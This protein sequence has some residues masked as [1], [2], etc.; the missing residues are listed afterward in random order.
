MEEL[1]PTNFNYILPP[2]DDDEEELSPKSNKKD[3]PQSKEPK[4]AEKTTDQK[5]TVE[6]EP[7]LDKLDASEKKIIAE[8]YIDGRR[9]DLQEG[10]NDNETTTDPVTQAADAAS[11]ELLNQIDNQ[12]AAGAE[13]TPESLDEA[14]DAAAE[15]LGLGDIEDEGSVPEDTDGDASED[16]DNPSG[17]A[18]TP[19]VPPFTPPGNQPLPPQGPRPPQGPN[20]PPPIGPN[21]PPVPP[22]G[23]IPP[24][25]GGFGPAPNMNINLPPIR[26][27]GMP[28]IPRMPEHSRHNRAGD[29]LLGGI[30]GYLIGRRRGRI[31]TERKLAPI[32]AK[33][34]EQVTDLQT[35]IAE[36]EAKI[37]KMA[38]QQV[39][40]EQPQS[41]GRAMA[42]PEQVATKQPLPSEQA[43][44]DIE[45]EVIM[46]PKRP[47]LGRLAME[48]EAATQ[49]IKEHLVES[50]Q[51]EHLVQTAPL[52]Q[53][54]VMAAAVGVEG[55]NLR[56]HYQEGRLDQLALRKILEAQAKGERYDLLTKELLGSKPTAHEQIEKVRQQPL[57]DLSNDVLAPNPEEL[58]LP[59]ELTSDFR[60]P[61][62][63]PS[64]ELFAGSSMLA[65]PAKTAKHQW[66]RPVLMILASLFI[67]W[68]AWY[69]VF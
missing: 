32:Q 38:R 37:R 50:R 30:I 14:L 36:R 54:L 28:N 18:S 3:R 57:Q 8:D 65:L 34:E 24:M 21:L 43:L 1:P 67:L 17:G 61:E 10:V 23:P 59:A 2:S 33:L 25:P 69:T 55:I 52:E 41:L 64:H 56:Q 46:P 48:G 51:P 15:N 22:V 53:L 12:L 16:A 31:K 40:A 58:A 47:I 66:L 45:L 42:A 4:G 6:S 13:P 19:P 20:L 68:L 29:I 7:P 9:A 5:E 26:P 27:I 49:P 62:L 11:V 63:D 39:A 44:P 60:L 35:Q